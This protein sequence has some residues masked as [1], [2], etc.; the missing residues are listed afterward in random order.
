MINEGTIVLR[1]VIAVVFG[2]L[3]GYEREKRKGEGYAGLRTHML[4]CLG[5]ALITIVGMFAF[6]GA[7][8]ARVAAGIVTGIGFLG[9]GTIIATRGK[10]KGLTTA[11]SLWV[12]A[13]IGMSVGVGF[14]LAALITTILALIILELWRVEGKKED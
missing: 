4:V 9:A 10:V 1:L 14:L 12:A 8:P 5:S 2:A 7:D 13:G 6:E 11:A 3:I